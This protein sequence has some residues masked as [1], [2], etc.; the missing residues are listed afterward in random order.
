[1]ANIKDSEFD[2]YL[3]LYDLPEIKHKERVSE[4]FFQH[5]KENIRFVVLAICNRNGETLYLRYFNKNVGWELPGGFIDQNESLVDAINRIVKDEAGTEI[6]EVQPIAYLENSFSCGDETVKH[7]GIGFVAI[8]DEEEASN[9]DN[10]KRCFSHNIPDNMA[11]QDEEVV[12]AA[13]P[14]IEEKI[15]NLPTDE[16][17]SSREFY[18]SHLVHKHLINRLFGERASRKQKKALVNEIDTA[19]SSILDAACGDD[20]TIFKLEKEF[21]PQLCL[22][23]DISWK[24]ISVVRNKFDEDDII[25]T[26]HNVLSLPYKK[27]FD[28]ILFKNSLHHIDNSKQKELISQLSKQ[29]KVLIVM[30]IKDPRNGNLKSRIWNWY[31]RKILGDQ[32]EDFLDYDGFKRIISSATSDRETNF[33]LVNTVKG[34]YMMAKVE[35]K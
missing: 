26:N 4:E 21:N 27:K 32:G 24:T 30:D 19:P 7:Q 6:D 8:T 10:I 25:F 22:A 3:S 14:Q 20:N 31:Y 15:G 18:L 34:E 11:Y 1:M 9:T 2:R 13:K 17:D 28:L 29:C 12:R 16:I 35:E 33:K 5:C 23:N